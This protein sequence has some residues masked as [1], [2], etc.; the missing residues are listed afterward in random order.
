[1]AK[2]RARA[3]GGNREAKLRSRG[4]PHVFVFD[5]A[6]IREVDRLAIDEFGMAGVVLMENAA[7]HALDV[8][9]DLVEGVERPTVAVLCGGGNN[10]GDGFAVAR[11]LSNAGLTVRV[12]MMTPMA[13]LSGDA[14]VNAMIAKRMGLELRSIATRGSVAR[15]ARGAHLIVDAL[16]G[17]GLD[18]PLAGAALRVVG[19]INAAAKKSGAT[20]LSLD[21][22]SGLDAEAGAA[23]GDAVRADVTVTFAGLKRGFL[24]PS[25]WAFLGEVIIADIG[26]PRGLIDR[27]G[28]RL[29]L[30]A[31]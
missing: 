26:A 8:A 21:L 12:G 3:S 15:L 16:F 7:R 23:L 19:E 2:E 24:E 11:H 14:Q 29:S 31:T 30:G 25:S 28:T 10:G 22:P 6:S 27:L 1:M 18:R 5:R 4:G 13:R 9:L 20:A 17:T